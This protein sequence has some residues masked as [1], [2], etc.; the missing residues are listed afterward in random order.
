M[1]H[2]NKK[3]KCRSV[4]EVLDKEAVS[5]QEK[6]DDLLNRVKILESKLIPDIE[7]YEELIEEDTK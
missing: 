3:K 2:E 7:D 4:K 6:F 5:I 1:R